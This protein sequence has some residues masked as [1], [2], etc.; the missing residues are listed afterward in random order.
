[1]ISRSGGGS[2]SGIRVGR[3]HFVQERRAGFLARSKV[4][5]HGNAGKRIPVCLERPRIRMRQCFHERTR[6][7]PPHRRA[8]PPRA[9]RPRRP[10]CRPRRVRRAGGVQAARI[11]EPLRLLTS[12][13]RLVPGICVPPAG[14]RPDGPALPGGRGACSR[15]QALHHDRE[16]TGEGDDRGEQGRG[17]S[18]V[19]RSLP[20]GSEAICGEAPAGGAGAEEDH[21]HRGPA[22]G[23]DGISAGHRPTGWTIR[24]PPGSGCTRAH[25]TADPRRTDDRRREPH[26]HHGLAGVRG[27][28]EEGE[29]GAGARQSRRDRR[30][31]AHRGAE[32]ARREAGEEE[33]VGPRE[34][35]AGGEGPRRGEVPVEARL[36]WSLWFRGEAGDRSRDAAREGRNVHGGELQGPLPGP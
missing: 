33:G 14:G 1:V 7:V 24:D 30:A 27:A 13:G 8:R 31:G 6:M 5:S 16:R 19:L 28:A 9:V 12:G 32:T 10:S 20:P 29:G 2:A 4:P 15:R 26:P 36:G 25:A 3:P 21:R 17:A 22:R 18:H 35:E 34:G 11:L 23:A